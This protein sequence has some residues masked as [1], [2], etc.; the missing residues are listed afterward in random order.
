MFPYQN[1]ELPVEERI[2]DLLARM[3]IEEKILQTDQYGSNDF[4]TQDEKRRERAAPRHDRRSGEYCAALCD[5]KHPVGHSLS[6][7]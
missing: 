4:T 7:Q 3:T 2:D 6:V 1:P 5:G